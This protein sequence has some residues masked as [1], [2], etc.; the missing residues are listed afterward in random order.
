M[1]KTV[2]LFGLHF[3]QD[4]PKKNTVLKLA[5][6]NFILLKRKISTI[7][8]NAIVLDPFSEHT[9]SLSDHKN[10]LRFGIV[11][12]DCSWAKIETIFKKPFKMGRKLPHLLAA[13]SVNYGKWDKLSSAEALAAALYITGF[14]K[15]AKEI[16]S[17]FS[18]G[19]SFWR[20]ND[21]IF[22]KLDKKIK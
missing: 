13:N 7:P 20:I 1:N 4:D 18:W 21:N 17:I 9:I 5:R 3:N 2:R 16:I 22:K 14:K 6:Q 19:D 10:I 11:V 15:L 8:R 12:I